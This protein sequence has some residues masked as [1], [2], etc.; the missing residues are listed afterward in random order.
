MSITPSRS[1]SGLPQSAAPPGPR[2]RRQSEFLLP[3][4]RSVLVALPKHIDALRKRYAQAHDADPPVQVEVVVHGSDEHRDYLR[5]SRAHHESRRAALRAQLGEEVADELETARAELDALDAQL[6]A[7][8]AAADESA[9]RLNPNFSKFGFDAQL[10]TYSDD[11]EVDP[12][13]GGVVSSSA[14]SYSVAKSDEVGVMKLVKR[15]V[16]RQYFHRGLLWYVAAQLPCTA[17]D[18]DRR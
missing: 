7:I 12:D 16:I 5:L 6:S 4:G 3:D 2:G 13:D 17:F 1:L 8:E 18:E 14:S 10:R 11:E 9:A 15:P